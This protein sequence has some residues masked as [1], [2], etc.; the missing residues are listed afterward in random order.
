MNQSKTDYFS[1]PSGLVKQLSRSA[2]TLMLASMSSLAVGQTYYVAPDG[3]DTNPGSLTSPF[4][5]LE[6]ARDTVRL[7]NEDM[8]EDIYIYIKGGNYPIDTPIEFDSRDSGQNGYSV[9]YAAYDSEEP[10]L[11]GATQVTGWS[12]HSGNIYKATLNRD[13]KLRTLIVNGERAYMASQRVGVTGSW[14]TYNITA[15]QATWARIDGSH[16][17]GVTY[18]LSD[19]PSISNVTDIE[20]MNQTKW[21]TNFVTVRETIIEDDNRVMKFSQPYAAIAMKQNWGGFTNSGNHTLLNAYEFL[22]DANEFYFDRSTDTLYYYTETVNM[23]TAEVWAPHASG[24]LN[25][26]G[27]SKANPVKNITFKGLTF[28]YTEATLPEVAGSA[29]KST[30]QASTYKM[31]YSD[32]NWHTDKY[33]AYD[34][35]PGAIN[36]NHGQYISFEDG[37][38]KHI[39]GEGINF[40]NDVLESQIIGNAFLDIGG[41]GIN[42]SHPQHVY[43]GDGG[44]YEKYPS[45]EEGVVQNILIKNNLIYDATRIYWGHA[46]ITAFFTNGLN[47]E[48]NQIQNTHY[49]GVSLGWGWN[50]F[51]PETTPDNYTTVARNNK[52]NNNRVYNV[53]TTLEDGGA[54]YTLGNQPNSEASRNYVKAPTTH[55]Q[56]V[57]HP[58][59]G[60][61]YYTGED[62]VFEIVPGQDNFE[63]NAWRDKRDN[64]YSNIYTTSSSNATGA[65]NS[66]ITD[67]HVISDADWPAEALDI[68]ANAGLESNYQYLLDDI[69]EPPEV[70]GLIGTATGDIIEA[71][72]GTLLGSGSI[73]N[74]SEASGEL[75]VENI[76]TN[77]SGIEFTDMPK[78]TALQ[79]RYTS[80]KTGTYSVYVNGAHQADVEYSSTG[81]WAGSYVLTETVLVD[82]PQGATLTLQKDSDDD[83]INI[84]YVL[85][86]DHSFK[87][88]AEDAD[89]LGNAKA[90]DEH[91]GYSGTGFAAQILN[92]GD[93]VEFSF[94]AGVAGQ[95]IIDM[96]YAMG[97]YGPSGDRTLSV[98]VNGSEQT[99]ANFQTTVEWNEW[100][101]TEHVVTLKE[102]QNTLRYQYDSGDSGY[103][104][105]DYI[106]LTQKT[107]AEDGLLNSVVVDNS[108]TGFSG[109]GF[110]ADIVHEDDSVALSVYAP[111]AGD[112]ELGVNYAMGPDGPSGDRSLSVYINNI[113]Q[114]DST[115]VSTGAWDSWASKQDVI[116]LN[117]GLS[118]IRFQ[119]DIDNTGWVNLDYITLG[120]ISD[121]DD[122]CSNGIEGD[123]DCDGQIDLEDRDLFLSAMGS[124]V[125]DEN[126]F[127]AADLD[128][129][130]GITRLD[131]SHWFV[132]YRNQ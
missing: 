114:G 41:S 110:V 76:H 57:Y 124:Q 39:G 100:A 111:T 62:L 94:N 22:D 12:H 116:S 40:T 129:D 86:I 23:D 7:V 75:A 53:M 66:S 29:G 36:V 59:E 18:N 127:A 104:N 30:V 16:P 117:A 84:D 121:S 11:N 33:T 55:F 70:P 46:A 106:E 52:F 44:A 68:I 113:D 9:I 20:I 6:K 126:Y 73:F 32:G 15:G 125:G 3:N 119:N 26:N 61:A 103:V 42:V 17:D 67:M 35:M 131:Y 85:L 13:E 107:E 50:N 90:Q 102:G 123:F 28:A 19:L 47:I 69:P 56:G 78:A 2:F 10:V 132:L 37:V 38:I 109:F 8:N 89:M 122:S 95:Y 108:H 120:L 4:K 49:T 5:T 98:Y 96:R 128:G 130:G 24:L 105:I 58:D 71:E 81:Q 1:S 87:Q 115:F 31:A 97:T 25:L 34:V 88:E 83:A 79:L 51:G 43:I 14:G 48:H 64:H 21:N 99:Q 101:N 91:S 60:T 112:Y 93:G 77:G 80:K 45:A 54:F 118:V 72:S 74:D 92:Q 27:D 65:P 82:I 63:L